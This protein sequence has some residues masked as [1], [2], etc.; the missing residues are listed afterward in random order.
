MKERNLNQSSD[1]IVHTLRPLHGVDIT[2]RVH[3]VQSV[4]VGGGDVLA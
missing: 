1:Y 2:S 4:I 3:L